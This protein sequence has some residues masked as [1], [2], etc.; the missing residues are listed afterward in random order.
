MPN[1]TEA[2][3]LPKQVRS[4]SA[5]NPI[6]VER[7]GLEENLWGDFYH[8]LLRTT[9]PR[10]FALFI[11]IYVLSNALFGLLYWLG[12]PCIENADPSSYLDHFFFSVQTMA[13]IGY[14]K[15]VRS[16]TPIRWS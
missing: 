5:T 2:D 8:F 3:N 13:T 4:F 6:P 14:G 9:W 1:P 11:G 12:N 10:F 7:L 16:T 15:M